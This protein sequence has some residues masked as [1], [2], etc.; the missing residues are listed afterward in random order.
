MNELS[1]MNPKISVAIENILYIGPP[2]K[3]KKQNSLEITF[4][5]KDALFPSK[6]KN[7]STN[8]SVNSSYGRD[9]MAA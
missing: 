1:K 3:P 8:L 6:M 4:M 2:E 9:L 5:A 7:R